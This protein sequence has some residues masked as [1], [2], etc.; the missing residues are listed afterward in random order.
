MFQPV[1][2]V[3]EPGSDR[4]YVSGKFPA[5]YVKTKPGAKLFQVLVE[6]KGVEP[7][8]GTLRVT[9][10][11]VVLGRARGGAHGT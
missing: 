8:D 4:V 1:Y 2:L 3:V 6:L 11:E 7:V 9:A 5:Q 10:E